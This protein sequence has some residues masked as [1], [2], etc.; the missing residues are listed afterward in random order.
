MSELARWELQENALSGTM[1]DVF[2]GLPKLTLWDTYGNQMTGDLPE[3]IQNVTGLEYL[4]IQAAHTDVL[5]NFRCR[6]RIPGLGNLH[7]DMNVP[8]KQAGIKFNW[9]IQVAEY[10]NYKYASACVDPFDVE[11]AFEE[12]SGDV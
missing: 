6:E 7:N 2:G 5:R 9:Y 11:T 8:S 1:P 10:Y 3:S 12:L 4:Y